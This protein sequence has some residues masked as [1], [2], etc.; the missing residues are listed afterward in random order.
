MLE[1]CYRAGLRVGL[2]I[3]PPLFLRPVYL[4]RRDDQQR[5]VAF[6]GSNRIPEFEEDEVRSPEAW[7]ALLCEIVWFTFCVWVTI[8][9]DAGEQMKSHKMWKEWAPY[10][11]RTLEPHS[12]DI[13][14]AYSSSR[15]LAS[16]LKPIISTVQQ[17][18]FSLSFTLLGPMR[19]F[20]FFKSFSTSPLQVS[21]I[22]TS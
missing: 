16:T 6:L 3:A 14:S 19:T 15:S 4:D 12:D 20:K 10:I 8:V 7:H 18:L 2:L 22:I 21:S 11:E 1:G 5:A 9:E 13:S 17:S